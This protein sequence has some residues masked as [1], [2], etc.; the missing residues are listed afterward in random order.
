MCR[1]S[2]AGVKSSAGACALTAKLKPSTRMIAI[3]FIEARIQIR[4]AQNGTRSRQARGCKLRQMHFGLEANGVYGKTQVAALHQRGLAVSVSAAHHPRVRSEHRD[5]KAAAVEG[6]GWQGH[7]ASPVATSRR[8][9]CTMNSM[10][11]S[12]LISLKLLSTVT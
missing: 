7:F 6:T 2:S 11:S 8:K 4:A 10:S 9:L 5:L 3:T 1:L 12:S